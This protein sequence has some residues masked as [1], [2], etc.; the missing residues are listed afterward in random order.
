MSILQCRIEVEALGREK[1]DDNDDDEDNKNTACSVIEKP[2][3]CDIDGTSSIN[4]KDSK[5]TIHINRDDGCEKSGRDECDGSEE[6]TLLTNK[7]TGDDEHNDDDDGEKKNI[8]YNSSCFDRLTVCC[9]N[10]LTAYRHR[11]GSPLQV[12]KIIII[13]FCCFG[14]NV[15]VI[16]FITALSI[17][18]VELK[19]AFPHDL[20][21][22]TL[23]VFLPTG[24]FGCSGVLAGYVVSKFG[25]RCAGV[26]GG[27]LLSLGCIICYFVPS[28]SYIIAFLGLFSGTGCS[29]IYISMNTSLAYHF[30]TLGRILISL[31]TLGESF[32]LIIS[33]LYTSYLVNTYSWRGSFVVL[34]A[35]FLNT[36][37]LILV[38]TTKTEYFNSRKR[39]NTEVSVG[40][41]GEEDK[42]ISIDSDQLSPRKQNSCI[43]ESAVAAVKGSDCLHNEQ[44]PEEKE[45]LTEPCLNA[46][47][48]VEDDVNKNGCPEDNAEI[49]NNEK[50]STLKNRNG[51]TS[52][53]S[54]NGISPDIKNEELN[55]STDISKV[56]K[57]NIFL[58]LGFLLSNKNFVLFLW[59]LFVCVGNSNTIITILPDF[60]YSLGISVNEA[61]W[62]FSVGAIGDIIARISGSFFLYLKF[63]SLLIFSSSVI[64]SSLV[65]FI[66]PFI[67]SVTA[68]TIVVFV[69]IL[70]GG[71]AFSVYT[72][73][74]LDFFNL[75]L[76]S[77]ST[78]LS[79]TA[80]GIGII[81]SG[82]IVGLITE[83]NNNDYTISFYFIA[84]LNIVA[85]L[86]AL[87]Y[88][89]YNRS[90]APTPNQSL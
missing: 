35:T 85:M 11:V 62:I 66:F 56:S 88:F 78:G 23:A 32:G 14:A 82:F 44:T 9:R 76:Y 24:I 67:T 81:L 52:T 1:S 61:A 18:Y 54:Q 21:S 84:S 6:V 28:I 16:G 8:S 10:N 90:K 75:E 79:E 48:A 63:P 57:K 45:L 73:V 53:S 27:I 87:I 74:V 46:D 30:P 36:V 19:I 33:P 20:K 68:I 40:E 34:G 47:G 65:A 83:Y 42:P 80:S 41:V 69:Y 43:S 4:D 25:S 3:N 37:P 64:I 26:T 2:D 22:V 17:Y 89:L 72:V 58:K 86:P 77:I 50:V 29:F 12:F 31:I 70:T 38:F 7:L 39:L 60:C 13:A 55:F 49:S 71:V 51:N 59:S 15:M 5:S